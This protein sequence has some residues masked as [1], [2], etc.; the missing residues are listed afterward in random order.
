MNYYYLSNPYNGT[1][2]EKLA[3][4]NI[5]AEVYFHLITNNIYV[6][7]PILHNHA[8]FTNPKIKTLQ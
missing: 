5:C 8:M 3:R 2:E 4:N 1:D 6:F 7:S